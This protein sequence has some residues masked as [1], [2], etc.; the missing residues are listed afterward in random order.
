MGALGERRANDPARR[1][2]LFGALAAVAAGIV[3]EIAGMVLAYVAPDRGG[4]GGGRVACG[5]VDDYEPGD[6]RLFPE[7][8]L[9]VVRRGDG[10][11]ALSQQCTHL[12]CLVPWD[13]EKREFH[14]PC[15]G[16]AFDE[17]GAVKGGP[18]PRPL[19]L[20]AL[21]ISDGA[22]VADTSKLTTRKSW[23]ADQVVK[24]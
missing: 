18:P 17:N 1:R 16:G 6:V 7:A 14:C 15:H 10:F 21:E 8:Q 19:D 4:A 23:S 9:Y 20:V 11:L 2:F 13:A 3:A 24:A 12:G 5:R 22:I